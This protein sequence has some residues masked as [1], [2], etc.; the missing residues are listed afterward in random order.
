MIDEHDD[1][2]RRCPPL[3]GPVP[4]KYCRT[5]NNKLPCHRILECWG[6][7]FD[8]AEWL[9]ENYTDNEIRQSMTPD[10]RSRLDKI[11]RAAHEAKK[12]EPGKGAD[13]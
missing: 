11:L 6:A 4:F 3:G 2:S 7:K 9:K 8:V 1:K 12:K 5:V 10:G 13:R